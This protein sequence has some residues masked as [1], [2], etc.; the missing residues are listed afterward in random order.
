MKGE[1]LSGIHPV[2]EAIR[3]GRRRFHRIHLVDG[4]RSRRPEAVAALAR[5]RKI[6]VE[7][8]PADRLSALSGDARHQG[9]AAEVG[10]YPPASL[11]EIS[12][13]AEPPL[14]MLLDSV[15]DVQNL[16][17]LLR[18][19]L[20]AGVTAVIFPRDRCAQPIPA[21]S[22]ASA[23][24]M[25][26]IPMVRVTNLARAVDR[27]KEMGLW[28]AGL[29]R[30]NGENLFRTELTGPLGLVIG[31]EERGIRPLVLKTCDFRISIPQRGPLDSLNASAAG[32]VALYEA[33]RQRAGL[34]PDA[35][36]DRQ[37]M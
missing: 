6:P 2:T 17:A 31:G 32:A 11:E 3:A 15:M 37:I 8:S 19:A 23:G 27:L 9:V 10:P 29:D 14:L 36:K 20:C 24:A 21:V 5:S 35:E 12:T 25:E 16:G 4:D 30:E 26:H 28:I 1:V 22:R 33:F 13:G 34:R 18:T 7:R